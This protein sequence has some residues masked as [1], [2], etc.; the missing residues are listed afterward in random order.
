MPAQA[1]TFQHENAFDF[2]MLPAATRQGGVPA[3]G[4]TRVAMD[5]HRLMNE[6]VGVA[7]IELE[8]A[9]QIAVDFSRRV[10]WWT[11]QPPSFPL[12]PRVARVRYAR[13]YR[14]DAPYLPSRSRELDELVWY[15]GRLAFAGEAAWWQTE[16]DRYRLAHWPNLTELAHEPEDM[17]MIALL[18]RGPLTVAGL[19]AASGGTLDSAVSLI[20]TLDLMGL[21]AA[22]PAGES[23]GVVPQ[24]K[25]AQRD[26]LFARLRARLVR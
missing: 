23:T 6:S 16:G 12:E 25:P 14:S 21:L 19:S 9:G 17:S 20:N 13:D 15:I 2:V 4:W 5:L 24:P 7:V 1:S 26:G 8:T 11:Q 10:Y 18:A 22:E 3:L